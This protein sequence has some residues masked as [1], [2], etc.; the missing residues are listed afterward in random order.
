M[1]Q[2]DDELEGMSLPILKKQK[3]KFTYF[4]LIILTLIFSGVDSIN[5][6]NFDEYSFGA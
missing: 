5:Y 1:E 6:V 2:L 3:T 4:W